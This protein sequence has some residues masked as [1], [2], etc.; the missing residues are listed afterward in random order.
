[1]FLALLVFRVLLVLLVL[2]A[3][4]ALF[5]VLPEILAL[6]VPKEKLAQKALKVRLAPLAPQEIQVRLF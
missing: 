4:P 6:L 5:P 3:L 2:P 1:L